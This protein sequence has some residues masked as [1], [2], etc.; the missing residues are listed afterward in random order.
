[1]RQLW[2]KRPALASQRQCV[3]ITSLD[4]VRYTC[5]PIFTVRRVYPKDIAAE[6]EQPEFPTLIRQFIYNKEHPDD[7]SDVSSSDDASNVSSFEDTSDTSSSE[8]ASDVTS[9]ILYF[10]D[11][12]NFYGMIR[13]Y[14]S[15]ALT[16]HAPHGISGNGFIRRERIRAVK[17]WRNG[18]G[19]YDTVIVNTGLYED[20]MR[21]MGVAR[22]R[23]LFSFSHFGVKYPC[24]L[25][26][27]LSRVDDS[28]EDMWVVQPDDEEG[29]ASV[30][31]LN[32]IVR[33][34]H[35]RQIS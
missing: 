20:G 19:R 11:I 24:A 32:T 12:H 27:W 8:D 13:I 17:S 7:A 2:M 29:P 25:V 16:L 21:R 15:A 5:L 30:I 22:V 6:I 4:T 18:P 10:P 33:I 3:S 23:L 9:S 35:L 14:P 34:A 26:R 28:P 31:H 1:M